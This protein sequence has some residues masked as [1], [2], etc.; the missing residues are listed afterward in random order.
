[1]KIT[2]AQLSPVVGAFE[3]NVK[4]IKD[5]YQIACKDQATLLLTPE[6]MLCG[7]PHYDWIERPEFIEQNVK[8]LDDILSLTRHQNCAIALGHT[9]PWESAHGRPAQNVV[10]ILQKGQIAFRQA[11]TLLPTYD[12][13]DEERYFEPSHAIQAFDLNGVSSVFSIC[14]DLWGRDRAV[15]S[16][17]LYLRDPLASYKELNAK[18]LFS[19]S[20]SPYEWGKRERRESVHRQVVEDLG[21]PLFY[22]NQVGATDEVLFDGCSFAMDAHGN[23]VER[24]PAFQTCVRTVDF[25]VIS[26][27]SLAE[28]EMIVLCQALIVG[29]RD[30]FERT[31]FKKAI[32]G[33]SG[34]IDSAVVAVLAVQALGA[35]NVLG[36]AMPSQYSSSHSLGDAELLAKS[37]KIPFQV[38]PIKFLNSTAVR[39]IGELRGGSLQSIALENLQSRLRGMVLMTLSNHDSALVLT[40]GNKS[41]IAM[42]YCTLYGDMNGALAPLGDLYKTQVYA[43]AH[44]LNQWLGEVI[45]E[46]TLTKAPSAELRP[47]QKDQDSLPPYEILD[48]F[49]QRYLERNL[50]LEDLQLQFKDLLPS[51]G[52]NSVF[53]LVHRLHVNEYKRKQAPPILRVSSKAFGIGRRVPIAKKWY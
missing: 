3:E 38:R 6:L 40:T 1:M 19:L 46:S 43:L 30:Y 8:A 49:L 25:P 52:R 31:G 42:G 13:F 21:V 27:A 24:L 50:S 20:S 18:V 11:K 16:R 44:H 17:Q 53:D 22:V 37:L 33:L 51:E 29:I 35:Q 34:G 26:K 47:N 10:S 4:K 48:A 28:E 7:Y 39:E 36:V 32:V 9:Q 2:L 14:E 15:S 45:P 23:V 5:A 41:E 12:I